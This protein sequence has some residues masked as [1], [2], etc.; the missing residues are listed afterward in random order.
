VQRRRHW[1]RS[2]RQ[3]P[4]LRR[5]VGRLHNRALFEVPQ[6]LAQVLDGS[7]VHE[8]RAAVMALS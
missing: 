5:D 2:S 4:T 3:L 1:R 8:G 7:A 6:I